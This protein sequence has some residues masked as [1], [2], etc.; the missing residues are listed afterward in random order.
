MRIQQNVGI[1]DNKGCRLLL[2]EHNKSI[3]RV[4]TCPRNYVP[5]AISQ[6]KMMKVTRLADQSHLQVSPHDQCRCQAYS[7]SHSNA[8]HSQGLTLEYSR[9]QIV[10]RATGIKIEQR[11]KFRR[12]CCCGNE[13]RTWSD[14]SDGQRCSY[15]PSFVFDSSI[16]KKSTDSLFHWWNP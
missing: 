2:H 13:A 16:K 6:I 8:P 1:S 10:S 15:R 7:H 11:G 4:C 14:L 12:C 3:S 9:C 5:V